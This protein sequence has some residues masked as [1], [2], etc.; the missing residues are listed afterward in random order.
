MN[1]PAAE[2]TIEAQRADWTF[3]SLNDDAEDARFFT[4]L[5]ADVAREI[6]RS[7]RGG[8]E[9]WVGREL[10]ARVGPYTVHARVASV[11]PPRATLIGERTQ[12]FARYRE[13]TKDQ[14]QDTTSF[15]AEV[16][17]YPAQREFRDL[18]DSLVGLDDIKR[19]LLA[20]LRLLLDPQ[21]INDWARAHYH[22]HQPHALLQ[23]LRDRYPL[24][25]LEGEVGS[26]KTALARSVGYPL[27]EELRRPV[28]LYVMNA[29]V[30]G[31][32]HVGELSLNIARA[33]GEAERAWER[34]R[35]PVLLLIDE[36]DALAQA[37][38]GRQRH[39]EDDAGVNTL[40][41][42]I[43]RLRGKPMAVLFATNLVQTLDSALLRRATGS[44]T[45]GRPD[46]QQRAETFQRLLAPLGVT[47]AQ[48]AELVRLTAPRPVRGFTTANQ[49]YTYS[50]LTQRLIP[51]AVEE[52]LASEQPLTFE[53]LLRACARVDPTPE[54]STPRDALGGEP[55]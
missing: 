19:D 13:R 36:A 4:T 14:G 9:V 21:R 27:A 7:F 43:D 55:R 15:I 12:I 16:I 51:A 46:D 8:G 30:R 28:T 6:A 3:T 41:Q 44:Y 54:S 26:G 5:Q 22:D 53:A 37:R 32:G 35:L 33:F 20:K 39:I 1:E 10:R 45:F 17:R 11:E 38:G 49:R 31:G 52:A 47:G 2:P 50:D 42:R 18:Y 34:E 29:Q 25:I 40:I 48:V 23:A 24:L